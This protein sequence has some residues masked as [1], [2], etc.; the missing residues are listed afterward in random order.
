ME[1]NAIW[2]GLLVGA[3]GCNGD[4]ETD[5]AGDDGTPGDTDTDEEEEENEV[6]PQGYAQLDP[7]LDAGEY[8]DWYCEAASRASTGVSPHGIVRVCSNEFASE[9]ATGEFPV[10]SASVKELYD[11]DMTTLVGYAVSIKVS[12]GTSGGTWYWYEQVP[13]GTTITGVTIDANGV[14]A[15][16]LGDDGS[17]AETICASCHSTASNDYVFVQVGE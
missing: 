4:D 9:H 2:L 8:L 12:T 6:P 1:R 13:P 11:V 16:G 3:W 15:D 5:T 10:D 7:W 14:V 17:Q